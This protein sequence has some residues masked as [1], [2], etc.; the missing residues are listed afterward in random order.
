MLTKRK[1]WTESKAINSA[2][3]PDANGEPETGARLPDALTVNAETVPEPELETNARLAGACG[4]ML[5]LTIVVL[6]H[7]ASTGRIPHMAKMGRTIVRRSRA[8]TEN[9]HPP[10]SHG[11]TEPRRKNKEGKSKPKAKTSPQRSE[12]KTEITERKLE[13]GDR[14]KSDENLLK[15]RKF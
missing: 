4:M 13:H 12:R 8:V 2:P 7:P 9:Q 5:P 3:A 11:G 14:R 10:R 6:P 1:L 15:K